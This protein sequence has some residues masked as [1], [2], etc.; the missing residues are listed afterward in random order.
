MIELKEQALWFAPF[1]FARILGLMERKIRKCEVSQLEVLTEMA[2]ETFTEAFASMNDPQDFQDYLNKAFN[3]DQMRKEMLTSGSEF[4]LLYEN[5]ILTGYFKTNLDNAQSDLKDPQAMELERIYVL[6]Q[7]QGWGHG[8]FMLDSAKK[9]ALSYRKSYIWLGVWKENPEAVRFYE[10]HG[11]RIF[12]EHPYYI[13][14][15]RQMD[16]LMRYDFITLP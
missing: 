1:L 16:W 9:L 7:Y 3:P 6:S 12:G 11:F 10:S 2:R 13:G 5:D 14:K 4:R 8:A 15:D